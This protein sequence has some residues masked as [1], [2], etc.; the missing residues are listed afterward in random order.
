MIAA[1]A[2]RLGASVATTNP[3]DFSRFTPAGLEIVG[4]EGRP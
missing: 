1:V 4:P 2:L 3:A